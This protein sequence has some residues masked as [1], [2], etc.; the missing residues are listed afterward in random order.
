MGHREINQMFQGYRAMY[1]GVK[2]SKPGSLDFSVGTLYTLQLTAFLFFF[3]SHSISPFFHIFLVLFLFFFFIF[4]LLWF[5]VRKVRSLFSLF[6]LPF[7]T[8][9]FFLFPGF[10]FFSIWAMC[11]SLFLVSRYLSIFSFMYLFEFF[12]LLH[13]DLKVFSIKLLL[14]CL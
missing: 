2:I 1:V 8:I 12:N 9:S 13:C 4:P 14:L 11:K 7:F 10:N 5:S 3:S 6:I